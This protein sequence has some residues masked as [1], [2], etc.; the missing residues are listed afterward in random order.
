MDCL[1]CCLISM[2]VGLVWHCDNLVEE[3]R[4]DYFA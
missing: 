3:G 2:F 1:V 4:D